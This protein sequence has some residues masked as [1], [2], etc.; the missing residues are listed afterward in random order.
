[1][2]SPDHISPVFINASMPPR[3]F[4]GRAAYAVLLIITGSAALLGSGGAAHSGPCT[5]Q[6]AQLERQIGHLT[7]GPVTGPTATQSVGAQLH[8]QPTPGAVQNAERRA[9]ADADAAIDRARKADADGNAAACS[10]ALEEARRL[11]DIH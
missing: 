5:E 10:R 4:I 11:Y 2:R 1:M 6:I 3:E 7:P 8:H 9:N